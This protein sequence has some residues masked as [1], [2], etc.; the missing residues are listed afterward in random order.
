MNGLPGDA[1]IAV[2]ARRRARGANHANDD[3]APD[4]GVV[5]GGSLVADLVAFQR[6]FVRMGEHEH[7][8]VALWLIHTHAIEAFDFTPYLV[9]TSPTKGCGKTTLA[10]KIPRLLAH[11]PRASGNVSG[12]ALFRTLTQG[13]TFLLDETDGVWKGNSERAED[14]RSILNAG[15]SRSEGHV[16]RCV[17]QGSNQTPTAFPVFGA[18]TIAGIGRLVPETVMDRG[19][20]IRLQKAP[21][22]ALEKLRER[23]SP[24]E[25]STLKERMAQW[26]AEHLEALKTAEPSLPDELDARGE[27]I[28]EPLIAIADMLGV[29]REARTAVVALRT[30]SEHANTELALQLLADCRGVFVGERIASKDLLEALIGLEASTWAAWWGEERDRKKGQMQIS[31]MLREFDIRPAKH[32]FPEYGTSLQGFLRGQF[33]YA[34]DTYLRPPSPSGTP[35]VGRSEDP[36]N[37]GVSGPLQRSEELSPLPT[38]E[39]AET[40]AGTPFF[41]PSDLDRVEGQTEDGNHAPDPAEPRPRRPLPGEDGFLEQLWPAFEAGHVAESEWVQLHRVHRRLQSAA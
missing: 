10:V 39:T 41:R 28:C 22:R 18:K 5:E 23:R 11:E 16:L 8:V 30:G 29:G 13:G 32:H 31:K 15:F 40:P 7:L 25:A 4:P 33:Q 27:D 12:P 20:G 6:R 37:H 1:E 26:A 24:V 38:P 19:L 17:G 9:I 36:R 35:E 34:W 3:C 21:K 14:L 2:A